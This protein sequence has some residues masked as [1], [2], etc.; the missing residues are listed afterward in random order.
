MHRSRPPSSPAG[1]TTRPVADHVAQFL[2]V[3][4]TVDGT[5]DEQKIATV[6]AF[7]S[8]LDVHADYIRQLG[9]W[10]SGT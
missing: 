7:A 9:A 1:S 5:V 2:T 4:A 8:A 3:M 10:P 6:E